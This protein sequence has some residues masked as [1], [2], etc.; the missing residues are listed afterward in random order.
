MLSTRI[1][2]KQQ[3]QQ[4]LFITIINNNTNTF[5]NKNYYSTTN[6]TTRTEHDSLGNIQVPSTA[7]YGAQTYRAVQNYPISNRTAHP[8]LIRA[9]LRIKSAAATANEKCQVLDSDKAK[10]IVQA[11]DE[12]LT[13][14]LISTWSEVF[15]VDAYQAGA[16]TSQ[17]M[18][19]NEVVAN[20]ANR[21]VGKRIGTYLPIHPNDH[22]NRS[23]STNDSFPTAMRLAIL[24]TSSELVKSLQELSQS[25]HNKSE[26]WKYIPKSAR[27]HLQDAV[28]M[29]LGQEFKAYSLT[30]KKC[31]TWIE[32][33]RDQ[34]REVG[35]GGSAAGTGLTVPK[36]YTTVMSQQL[37]H[38]TGEKI[39]IAENL[40]EAMQSQFPVLFY[41]SMLRLS[42]LEL[43]R[44]CNDLRL[45]ASGPMTGLSEILLP[46][47]QP[48][49]SIMPGKV[50]PSIIE[51][52]NQTWYSVIGYDQAVVGC[53]Q[54]GQLELNVMMPMMAYSMLEATTVATNATRV[55]KTR[56]IDGLQ[57]NE[58]RLR[59]YFESTPQVATVL[60]P[61]LG[62]EITAKLVKES[63]EREMSVI[64]LVREKKLIEEHELLKL[65][66]VK[67]LTGVE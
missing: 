9:Y 20:V 11:V 44:I 39:R 55:L 51:M 67:G 30:I 60:S 54:A 26:T 18:N 65:L 61:K 42:A 50:N 16:G 3:Q 49:S 7:L 15:P 45:M 29:T 52:A 21:I 25:F 19:M 34:L 62:Y 13:Q 10:L 2:P 43:T 59:K 24:D 33:G 23:Q 47:V 46:A 5:F 57:P 4:Q 31:A 8:A 66:E 35:I 63:L 40:C 17:N 28:P 6:Q 38:L 22:V 14:I 58:P 48:G 64:D 41:S 36:G 27:T 37:S 53:G 32:N 1:I 56:C 12:I